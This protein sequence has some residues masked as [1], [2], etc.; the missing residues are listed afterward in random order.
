MPGH[1]YLYVENISQF[2]SCLKEAVVRPVA[3][4]QADPFVKS[5]SSLMYVFVP[6]QCSFF[7]REDALANH[8][9]DPK[10][11][12]NLR[13]QT[14]EDENL[15]VQNSTTAAS[16]D[17]LVDSSFSSTLLRYLT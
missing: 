13:K 14:E 8:R 9:I 1:S 12:E 3:E 5:V 4:T 17:R 7:V 16:A 6:Q 11:D 15:L 10:L 2:K